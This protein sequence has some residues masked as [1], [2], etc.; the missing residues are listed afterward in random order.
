MELFSEGIKY[1]PYSNYWDLWA[2]FEKIR[3][4]T[5]AKKFYKNN[6]FPISSK[7]LISE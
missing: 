2:S 6:L 1:S 3:D 7:D 5:L 4:E